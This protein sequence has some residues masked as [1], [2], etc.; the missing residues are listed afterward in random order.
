MQPQSECPQ[1]LKSRR[2]RLVL[3]SRPLDDLDVSDTLSASPP[4]ATSANFPVP[5]DH[6]FV[7]LRPRIVGNCPRSR[8]LLCSLTRMGLPTHFW[9]GGYDKAALGVPQILL[10]SFGA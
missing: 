2:G 6:V 3:S 9:H 5:P 1:H 7:P 4:P 10:L 8:F